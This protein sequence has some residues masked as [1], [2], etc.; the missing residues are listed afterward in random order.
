MEKV[1]RDGY[2]PKDQRKTLLIIA[3]DPRVHS[4]VGGQAREIIFSTCHKYNW[5]A[6]GAV[7]NHPEIGKLVDISQAVTQ[8]TGV[9]D[10]FA[11]IYPFNGYGDPGILRHIMMHDKP[12]AVIPFTDPRFYPWLF[13]LEAEIR[14]HIPICYYSIW[15]AADPYPKYNESYYRSCDSIFC[16]SKQTY[17]V[18]KQVCQKEPRQ[19]WQLTYLPHGINTD[20]FKRLSESND[21]MNVEEMRK[22]LFGNDDVE[23]VVMYD[24]RNIRRKLV[25]NVILAYQEFLKGLKPEQREKCRLLL[26]TQPV[27]DNGTDIPRVLRDVAPEVKYVFSPQGLTPHQ[28]NLLYN[29]SDVMLSM[30]NAEGFGL[31]S[32]CMIASEKLVIAPVIGGL[33]DQAGFVDENGEY[34][35]PEKHFNKNWGSNCDGRYKTCGDWFLPCFPVATELTGSPPTPYIFNYFADWHEA[36]QKIKQVYEMEPEERERRGKLGREFVKGPAKM[37]SIALGEGFINSME[38]V[39]ANWKPRKRYVLEK[40]I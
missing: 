5:I 9:E 32:L 11:R 34:L 14:E 33:Q 7:I 27:D 35:D 30:S 20:I 15:D 19:P 21:L 8:E 40:A 4:G 38:G 37:T 2:I 3:D 13:Q 36:A 23:F 26:H 18:V 39:F 28:M 22:K 31:S 25:G 29:I 17:N 12:S 24:N 6:I 16:I 1:I 10:A